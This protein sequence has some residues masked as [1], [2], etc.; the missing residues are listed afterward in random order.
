M[1]IL[2]I[3]YGQMGQAIEQYAL[4]RNHKITGIVNIDNPEDLRNYNSNNTDVAIEF[5]Q[6]NC[7]FDNIKTCLDNGIP[8]ISGTTGW[9]YRHQEIVDHAKMLGGSFLY[10]S[11]FS[12]G[13]NLF[14]KLNKWLAKL[15]QNHSSY[16]PTIEEI[17][18]SKKKDAPSGTA[19]TVAEGIIDQYSSLKNWSLG[20][21]V[22]DT[23]GIGSLRQGDV[24]GIHT[25]NYKSDVDS[26]QIRHEAFSRQ[27]F[28][29]GAVLV[30]EWLRDKKG[31][32]TMD[33]FL[34]L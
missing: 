16:K 15:M 34:G 30:A 24:P 27:G 20:D 17:H 5:T 28:V 11:N 25:V 26:I 21:S 9:L 4:S 19:I 14:F 7:A 23:V 22:G 12:L 1:R 31:V 29:M 6:P 18:H 8:V 10:A 32:F 2:L 3:G 13:V 33:D